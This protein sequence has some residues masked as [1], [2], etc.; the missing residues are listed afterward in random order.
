MS[1]RRSNA[2]DVIEA[3]PPN[4][5]TAVDATRRS[6]CMRRFRI[7]RSS[8]SSGCCAKLRL[9]GREKL[10]TV[11]SDSDLDLSHRCLGVTCHC[12]CGAI[13]APFRPGHRGIS[14]FV[15]PAGIDTRLP[16]MRRASRFGD[17]G[18]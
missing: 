9:P 15:R 3:S 5:A 12:H 13:T 16:K 8:P 7:E 1:R 18:H 17:D 4:S 2:R 11:A 10:G 14:F 6:R